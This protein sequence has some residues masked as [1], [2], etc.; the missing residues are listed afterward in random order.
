MSVTPNMNKSLSEI[1]DIELTQTDKPLAEI[2]MDAKVDDIDSLEKQREYVKSNL[3]KLIEKGTS[4]LDN[5]LTIANSTENAKDFTVV[6]DLIKTLIATNV[7]LL[8]SE[9]A[10]KPK[11]VGA[12][13]KQ[14]ST[15][16][17]NNTVFVGSTSEL[18]KYIKEIT[19]KQEKQ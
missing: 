2:A 13:D 15:Q 17:T 19:L 9:V 1:F 12:Q 3:I 5:M 10:H 6:S 8:D 11:N 18:S 7:T 4:A 16:V 14:D